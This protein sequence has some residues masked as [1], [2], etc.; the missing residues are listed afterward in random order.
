VATRFS[1]VGSHSSSSAIFERDIE[2]ISFQG[3]PLKNTDP[4]HISR[5]QAHEPVE[6][7]V[8]SVLA[9]AVSALSLSPS[10]PAS[11]AGAAYKRRS[12]YDDGEISVIAPA[13]AASP[14]TVVG[15]SPGQSLMLSGMATPRSVSRSP[16]PPATATIAS[17]CQSQQPQQTPTGTTSPSSILTGS[18]SRRSASPR[19]L[20][21]TASSPPSA[22]KP[23]I[24]EGNAEAETRSDSASLSSP[25]GS[26]VVGSSPIPRTRPSQTSL[27][28][29][30]G[31]SGDFVGEDAFASGSPNNRLSF[32]SYHVSRSPPCHCSISGRAQPQA[33]W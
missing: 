25:I 11:P 26:F 10:T 16:S 24:T 19:P 27:I 18:A 22:F 5:A 17:T 20:E 9:S 13:A 14:V 15:N 21:T 7:S 2:P 1:A 3:S 30:A 31:I 8:P 28:T 4:H 32:I 29:S 6:Q 12:I 33:S 23:A